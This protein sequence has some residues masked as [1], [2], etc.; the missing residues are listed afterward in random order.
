MDGRVLTFELRYLT[1]RFEFY[2]SKTLIETIDGLADRL[3]DSGFTFDDER[4]V[5]WA[6]HDD[7]DAMLLDLNTIL[8]NLA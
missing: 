7:V 5:K 6:C 2:A 4:G 8:G 3:R 1:N